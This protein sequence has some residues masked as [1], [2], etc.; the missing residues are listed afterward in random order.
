MICTQ[1]RHFQRLWCWLIA[2]LMVVAVA[3]VPASSAAKAGTDASLRGKLDLEAFPTTTTFLLMSSTVERKVSYVLLSDFKVVGGKVR[4]LVD[5]G[6]SWPYGLAYD[7]RTSVLYVADTGLRSVVCYNIQVRI[8]PEGHGTPFELAVHGAK[9]VVVQ[10]VLASWV[11][12]DNEGNLFYTDQETRTVNRIHHQLLWQLR[13]GRVSASELRRVT[14]EELRVASALAEVVEKPADSPAE[15]LAETLDS[16]SDR[17]SAA[18]ANVLSLHQAGDV[19]PDGVAADGGEL[20][21]VDDKG[22]VNR[23]SAEEPSD[24][25]VMSSVQLRAHG[26]AATSNM[27]IFTTENAEVYG[28][29]K[30]GGNAVPLSQDFHSPRGVVWD[31]DNTVYIADT[32]TNAVYSMPC[33]RL[34]ERQPLERIL[35]MHGPFGLALIRTSDVAFAE[36][37]HGDVVA[38]AAAHGESW[39]SSVTSW[40]R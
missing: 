39:W 20:Y 26:I 9:S 7:Q 28:V 3:P 8:M 33:G 1:D 24:A 31:G 23:I 21:W 6:L 34:A 10:N 15:A 5:D 37:I 30:T 19:V 38:V 16:S 25:L 14:E 40:L 29:R 11:T 27:V 32:G 22:G 18:P 12:V 4:A 36:A 17:R 2:M 13:Q 35:E